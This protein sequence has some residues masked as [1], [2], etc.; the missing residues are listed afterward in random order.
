M[1]DHPTGAER[2]DV[3]AWASAKQTPAIW[4]KAAAVMHH[5]PLGELLTEAEYDQAIH[6][7]KHGEHAR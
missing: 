7:A 5:W 4:F 2:R 6:Q 1:S 3:E